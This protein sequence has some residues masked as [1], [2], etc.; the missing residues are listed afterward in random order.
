MIDLQ[1]QVTAQIKT[2]SGNESKNISLSCVVIIDFLS[3]TRFKTQIER[4]SGTHFQKFIYEIPVETP[5]QK[6]T[7][8][9]RNIH[10]AKEFL[11]SVD[12]KIGSN[13]LLQWIPFAI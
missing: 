7:G 10:I 6:I 9:K 11:R 4:S 8:T 13:L 5:S 3:D 2:N 1:P 12:V